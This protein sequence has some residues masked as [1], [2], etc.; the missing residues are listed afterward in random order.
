MKKLVFLSIIVVALIFFATHRFLG[1]YSE[2]KAAAEAEKEK[3]AVIKKEM[4]I[5]YPLCAGAKTI[6]ITPSKEEINGF[7]EVIINAVPGCYTAPVIIIREKIVFVESFSSGFIFRK[8]SDE[9]NLHEEHQGSPSIYRG[10]M[11]NGVQWQF[12][13]KEKPETVK[14]RVAVIRERLYDNL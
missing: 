2:K 10:H 4:A 6:Y 12:M 1:I 11:P 9:F 5:D 8:D 14:I 13:A 7:K 3:I